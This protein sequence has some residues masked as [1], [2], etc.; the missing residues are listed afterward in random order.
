M[1]FIHIDGISKTINVRRLADTDKC[2]FVISSNIQ[3]VKFNHV[4]M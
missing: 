2:I 4:A 3:R 1:V